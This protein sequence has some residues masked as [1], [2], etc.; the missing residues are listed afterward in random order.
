[1]NFSDIPRPP[2]TSSRA[3]PKVSHHVLAKEGVECDAIEFDRTEP[4]C[5][6][7]K[8]NIF[9]PNLA[10]FSENEVLNDVRRAQPQTALVDRFEKLEDVFRLA[11]IESDD[12]GLI[13]QL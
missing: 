4:T 8:I 2:R 9:V 5:P 10:A 12:D 13:L 6:R 1:M 11:H 7:S 3:S